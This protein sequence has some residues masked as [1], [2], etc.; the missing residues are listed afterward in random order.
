[1]AE[2]GAGAVAQVVEGTKEAIAVVGAV[3]SVI[4]NLRDSKPEYREKTT[5]A[6]ERDRKM[7]DSVAR[8]MK[9]DRRGFGDFVEE[10]KAASGRGPSETYT[11][12]ELKELAKEFLELNK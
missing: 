4:N 2:A 5:G 9:V 11:Y 6:N 12:K 8:E 1:M 7:I 10:T 3:L